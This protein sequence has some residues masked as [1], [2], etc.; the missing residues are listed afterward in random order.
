MEFIDKF[1]EISEN[2]P[3]KIDHVENEATTK[4]AFIVPF[5]EA[6]GYDHSDPSEVVPEYTADIGTKKGEKVDYAIIIDKKPVILIECKS[7]HSI[8]DKED[9]SQLYRYFNSTTSRIGILTNGIIYKFYSDT[10]NQN[11]MDLKPFLE[12]D[13]LNLKEPLIKELKRFRKKSFDLNEILNAAEQLKYKSEI[14]KVISDQINDPNNEF[15]KFFIKQIY[16][17]T[18][19]QNVRNQFKPLVKSSFN[20]FIKEK[21]DSRLKTALDASEKEQEFTS[22]INNSETIRKPNLVQYG[23]KSKNYKFKTLSSFSF[24]GKKFESNT[25]RDI[26]IEIC[27]I[28]Y[29]KHENDFSRVFSLKGRTR[30][31]FSMNPN[32]LLAPK[33]IGNSEVFI[34]C[35][36]SANDLVSLSK[37]II[38]LFG[39]NY[40]DLIIETKDVI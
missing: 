35:N 26:P 40:D 17:G 21:V 34:E 16:S 5:I 13:M 28:L 14:K 2:I 36:F 38:E 33:K 22:N 8:L 37:R 27:N 18:I 25:W 39:Y 3:K 10:E 12:I 32:E 11:Q 1:K 20:E 15:V 30:E 7:C 29:K 9:T 4:T 31:Y 23:K 24:D 19:T 6:L